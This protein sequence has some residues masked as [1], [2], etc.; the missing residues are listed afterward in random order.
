MK[1]QKDWM[2]CKLLIISIFC[3]CNKMH[4]QKMNALGSWDQLLLVKLNAESNIRPNSAALP[5]RWN[6]EQLPFF[7]RIEYQWAKSNKIPVKFRLGSVE[8][9]DWLEGKSNY[10]KQ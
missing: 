7:C 2:I 3:M 5:P 6:R 1:A 10:I 8:Y 9:V 4:A